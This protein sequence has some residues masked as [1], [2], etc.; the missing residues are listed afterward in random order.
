MKITL[1]KFEEYSISYINN[2]F[3]IE[4][5]NNAADNEYYINS[6]AIDNEYV[7]KYK[8]EVNSIPSQQYN[9]TYKNQ[10]PKTKK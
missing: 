5:Y 2:N 4:Q 9:N 8:S 3:N 10:L 1:K 7:L 6:E